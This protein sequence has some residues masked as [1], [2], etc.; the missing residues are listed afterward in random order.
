M[1][2]IL[3][4]LR[5]MI[6]RKCKGTKTH[7]TNNQYEFPWYTNLWSMKIIMILQSM[8]AKEVYLFQECEKYLNI[9]P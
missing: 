6:Y 1:E 5:K 4:S 7:G 9:V 2:S 8:H 3:G